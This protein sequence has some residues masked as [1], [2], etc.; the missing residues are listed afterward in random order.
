MNG[1]HQALSMFAL[2]LG[3]L[4]HEKVT[5]M[6]QYVLTHKDKIELKE[7]L[8]LKEEQGGFAGNT[9]RTW[10]VQPS[11]AWA[12]VQVLVDANGKEK[13]ATRKE[14][15]GTLDQRE[16]NELAKTL[17]AKDLAG[18][19][20]ELGRKS[21]VNPH[22][23]VLKFGKH[24][25]RLEGALPR[26]AGPIQENIIRSAPKVETEQDAWLRFAAIAHVIETVT[27]QR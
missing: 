17:A 16:V 1:I 22:R 25:S 24:E 21:T 6:E 5:Q 3:P 9:V 18:L 20:G 7:S 27:K 14:L 11:G 15:K 2:L 10:T 12:F 23:Y 19:P 26:R 4:T 8:V 13:A